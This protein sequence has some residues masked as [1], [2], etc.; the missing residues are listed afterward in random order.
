MAKEKA[1]AEAPADELDLLKLYFWL[2]LVLTVALAGVWLYHRSVLQDKLALA[3]DGRRRLAPLAEEKQA[4]Q[5]MMNVYTTNKED[6]ATERPLTWFSNAW[7]RVGIPDSAI[8]LD[9]WKEET[10]SREG[11]IQKYATLRFRKQEPLTRE[12]IAKLAHA[13]EAQSTRIKVIELEMR[14]AGGREDVTD[15]WAG[16]LKVGFRYPIVSNQ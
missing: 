4:V 16:E 8:K 5:A 10:K 14:R 9:P 12:Q 3:E 2:L 7:T 1:P 11:F 13:I 6:D 15:A